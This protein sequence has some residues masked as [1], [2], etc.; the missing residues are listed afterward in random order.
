MLRDV[1]C[2]KLSL[3]FC[4]SLDFIY[5]VRSCKWEL[6]HL[7]AARAV[8]VLRTHQA[9]P[10]ISGMFIHFHLLLAIEIDMP[11]GDDLIANPEFGENFKGWTE[12]DLAPVIYSLLS[13]MPHKYWVFFFTHLS[14]GVSFA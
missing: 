9:V 4:C 14:L 1:D 6:Y 11:W 7:P 3:G 8:D 5:H 2:V 12:E 10:T 13:S